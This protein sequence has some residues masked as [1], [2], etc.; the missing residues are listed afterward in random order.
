VDSTP[1][2]PRGASGR[3]SRVKSLSF[4]SP[5]PRLDDRGKPYELVP[6]EVLEGA[7]WERT[8]R[9]VVIRRLWQLAVIGAFIAFL[10]I[11][12]GWLSGGFSPWVFAGVP[13]LL[14]SFIAMNRKPQPLPGLLAAHRRCGACAYN[15]H[16]TAPEQDGCVVCPECGAAWHRDRFTL[17]E[18]DAAADA[19]VAKIVAWSTTSYTFDDRGVPTIEPTHWPTRWFRKETAP[20]GISSELRRYHEQSW[21]RGARIGVYVGAAM[22]VLSMSMFMISQHQERSF[23][24][25]A[26]V[27]GILLGVLAV[28]VWKV[29]SQEVLRRRMRGAVID[30]FGVCLACGDTLPADAPPTFDGCVACRACGRAWK[31]VQA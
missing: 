25:M 11:R 9:Q 12:N 26:I 28:V 18:K 14:I 5:P 7:L 24:G 4:L 3:L 27:V 20:H 23:V 2:G 6:P 31:R 30:R 1:R 16:E 8:P 22:W 17:A 21:A 29:V 19:F 13:V 10:G 15:L